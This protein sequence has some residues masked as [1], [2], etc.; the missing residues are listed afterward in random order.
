MLSKTGQETNFK[1]IKAMQVTYRSSPVDTKSWGV[2][3]HYVLTDF[4][5]MY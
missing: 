3:V 4:T 5:G 2:E 1:Q